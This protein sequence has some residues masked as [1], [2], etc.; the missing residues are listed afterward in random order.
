M[1]DVSNIMTFGGLGAVVVNDSEQFV[2]SLSRC[3]LVPENSQQIESQV[4]IKKTPEK[5]KRLKGIH[6]IPM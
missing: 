5:D 4:S 6:K 2:L 3:V 1:V